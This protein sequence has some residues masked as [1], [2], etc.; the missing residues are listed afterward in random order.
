MQSGQLTLSEISSHDYL[1]CF[2][3]GMDE[4]LGLGN[5]V[6]TGSGQSNEYHSR[7]A[8]YAGCKVNHDIGRVD[9]DMIKPPLVRFARE[10]G[11][12]CIQ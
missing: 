10:F 9:F 7:M 8:I 3:P 4:Q 12:I 6:E 5:H 2:F 1:A 11:N